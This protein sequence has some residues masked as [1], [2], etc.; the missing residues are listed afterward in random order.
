MHL[1]L[2]FN[3][4]ENILIQSDLFQRVADAQYPQ[5]HYTLNFAK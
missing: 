4:K 2:H 5:S 1:G 3:V